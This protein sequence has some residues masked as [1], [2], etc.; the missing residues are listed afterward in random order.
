M[1][2]NN[3]GQGVLKA[4]RDNLKVRWIKKIPKKTM[5]IMILQLFNYIGP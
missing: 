5:E 4:D 3:F 1:L 2:V